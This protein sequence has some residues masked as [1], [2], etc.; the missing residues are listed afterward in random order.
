V[1]DTLKGLSEEGRSVV[2]A[3][4]DPRVFPYGDRLVQIEDGKV[5]SDTGSQ[6]KD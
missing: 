1:L 3:T 2:L 5:T 6:I 4:H